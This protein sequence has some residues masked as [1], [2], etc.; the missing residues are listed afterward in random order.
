MPA[1]ISHKNKYIYYY[2]PKVA[3]STIRKMLANFEGIEWKHAWDGKTDFSYIDPKQITKHLTYFKFAF[4]RNPWDR[5]VSCYFDKVVSVKSMKKD[6]FKNF[7]NCVSGGEYI[8]FKKYGK[9]FK[10]MEFPEFAEFVCTLRDSES[11]GHFRSQHTFVGNT[12]FV[13]RFENLHDDL[14]KLR[15]KLRM[16]IQEEH[17]MKSAHR[18]Y[19]DY[20][21]DKL[22]NMVSKRYTVDIKLYGYKY[23]NII[24]HKYTICLECSRYNQINCRRGG[25]QRTYCKNHRPQ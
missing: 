19:K 8:N 6:D 9:D 16:N 18:N 24:L 3:C 4:V 7:N 1:I 14:N 22:I 5:L 17:L 20:Y 25:S 11:D 15:K 2:V 13:G 21:D 10:N 23:E 12:D